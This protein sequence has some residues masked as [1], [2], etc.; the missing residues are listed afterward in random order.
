MTWH[1]EI[2]PP[3]SGWGLALD[4]FGIAVACATLFAVGVFVGMWI[5]GSPAP[6]QPA[7]GWSRPA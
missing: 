5:A 3:R 4:V 6:Q 7:A 2:A 1:F